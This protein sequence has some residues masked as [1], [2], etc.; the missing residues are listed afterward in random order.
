MTQEIGGDTRHEAWLTQ[1]ALIRRW[2]AFVA[3]VV[4]GILLAC[5]GVALLVI[6]ATFTT[7]L[8]LPQYGWLSDTEWAF[9]TSWYGGAAQA[10]LPILLVLN[11]WLIWRLTRDYRGS[12]RRSR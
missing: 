1:L 12:A 8:F 3:A 11:P 5:A 2:L 4:G 7:H 9:L 6:L 10:A